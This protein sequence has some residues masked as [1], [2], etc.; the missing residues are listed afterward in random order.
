MLLFLTTF[1]HFEEK[2]VFFKGKKID[3]GDV[4][5]FTTSDGHEQKATAIAVRNNLLEVRRDAW[6]VRLLSEDEVVHIS[7]FRT[8]EAQFA[9]RSKFHYLQRLRAPA[10]EGYA[11]ALYGNRVMLCDENGRHFTAR[12]P[13]LRPV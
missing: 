7:V 5:R 12:Q 3:T 1:S 8:A 10:G 2:T 9:K 6:F 11:V 4:V 13:N